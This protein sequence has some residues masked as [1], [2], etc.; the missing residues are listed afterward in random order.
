MSL[1][2]LTKIYICKSSSDLN[3]LEYTYVRKISCKINM[4]YSGWVVFKKKI[5]QWPYQIFVITSPLKRS[6]SFICTILKS[7]YQR[8]ICTMFDWNLPAASGEDLFFNINTCNYGF[9][10][11][12]PP[13][14]W[15]SWFEE[16][17]IYIM[18]ESFHVNMTFSSSVVLE[19]M[20]KWP[21]PIFVTISP[22]KRNW[23]FIWTIQNPIYLKMICTK[24]N[25]NWPTCS[26]GEDFFP[27]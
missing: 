10:I 16:I 8:I 19:K 1:D 25:W 20:F 11:M 15:G 9:P 7:L 27:I 4:T 5:F 2:Y 21:Y 26:G 3:K 24:R 14:P 17:W 18:S 22:L 6:W 13:D 12:A 23:S